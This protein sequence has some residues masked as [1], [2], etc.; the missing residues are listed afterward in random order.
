MSRVTDRLIVEALAAKGWRGAVLPA[1]RIDDLRSEIESR[2]SD[3]GA[4][5]MEVVDRN[6]RFGPAAGSIARS[7]VI[8]A[9]PHATARVTLTFD[10]ETIVVPIPTT[11][12]HHDAIHDEVVAAVGAA[13][14]PTGHRAWTADLPEKLLA[15]C[16]GLAWYGRNNVAYVG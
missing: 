7:L 8:V 12:C 3:A 4:A 14:S 15:V 11:Y 16:A 5:V 1:V 13:L 10:D 6:L 2:R 9:V